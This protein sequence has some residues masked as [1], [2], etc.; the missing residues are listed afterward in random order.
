LNE[1][2][3]AAY[4]V[5]E[6]AKLLRIG[7]R[8]CREALIRGELPGHKIGGSWRISVEA[9]HRWLDGEPPDKDMGAQQEPTMP[10]SDNRALAALAA[11]P[12]ETRDAMGR[13]IATEV[14]AAIDRLA[15]EGRRKMA[16]GNEVASSPGDE[17][18]FCPE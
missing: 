16:L 17:K 11:L 18:P 12:Q 4:R 3:P 6:V 13:A 5:T 7:E 14:V 9:I 10:P 15:A 1:S 2:P 8:Q